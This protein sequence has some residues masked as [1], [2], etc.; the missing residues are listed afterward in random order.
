MSLVLVLMIITGANPGFQVRGGAL[1]KNCAERREA[2]TFFPILVGGAGCAPPWIRP[3]I[4]LLRNCCRLQQDI[5]SLSKS[6]L[7]SFCSQNKYTLI[8]EPTILRSCDLL[9]E[10]MSCWRRQ[11]FLNNVIQGRIQGGAHPAPPLKLEK[12]RFFSSAQ[13]F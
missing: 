3:W 1:K 4:T 11:Q 2:R 13:F 10:Y 7:F 9:S 12:I 6:Q 8:L 5:Y